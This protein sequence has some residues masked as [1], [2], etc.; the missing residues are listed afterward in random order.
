MTSDLNQNMGGSSETIET[1]PLR[2]TSH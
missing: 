1:E 2:L